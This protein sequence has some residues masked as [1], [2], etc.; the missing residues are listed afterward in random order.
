MEELGTQFRQWLLRQ[1]VCDQTPQRLDDNHYR[2]QTE[3]VRADVRMRDEGDARELVEMRMG[4]IGSTPPTFLVRFVLNDLRHA[5]D[6]FREISRACAAETRRGPVRILVCGSMSA[7]AKEF[8]QRLREQASQFSL[9]YEVDSCSVAE[10]FARGN[11]HVVYMLTPDVAHLRRRLAEACPDSVAFP[12]P[13]A[14]YQRKDAKAALNLMLEALHEIESTHSVHAAPP[15]LARPLPRAGRVLVLNIM[16]GDRSVRMG[17]RVYDGST[18]IARGVVIKARLSMRDIDDLL[19]TLCVEGVDKRTLDAV[20]ISVPGVVN[21]YS[22]NLPGLGDRDPSICEKIEARHGIKTYI[23]NSTNAAAMGCYLLQAEGDSLTLYRHQLGHK[24]GGQG[25]II[26]GRLVTGRFCLAGEPKFYQRNFA[27]AGTYAE[28]VWSDEG[29][30]EICR[31]VLLATI[32]TVS[33]DVAYV[34]VSTV[35]DVDGVCLALERKLPKYCIPALE[36]IHDYRERMYL[37][38][39]ALCLGRL[40]EAQDAPCES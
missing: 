22:M 3:L 12:L 16:Y 28:S 15:T 8:V 38:E 7:H 29:L 40:A 31:N 36:A 9:A 23:D 6:L 39:A 18:P 19:E 24:N 5:R 33:P 26:G 25:T 30:A 11:Q 10:A 1:R 14:L 21:C 34:S 35:E 17:Y 20:G 13:R 4:R 27:Y 37:G 32:G 2:V